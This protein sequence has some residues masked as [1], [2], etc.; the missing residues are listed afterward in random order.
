VLSTYSRQ[1][2]ILIGTPVANRVRPELEGLVGLFANTLVLRTDTSGD[3]SFRELVRRVRDLT[4]QA[5]AHQDLPFERLVDEL[6]VER[7]LSHNPLFQ[8]MLA[9]QHGAFGQHELPGLTLAGLN[10]RTRTSKFDLTLEVE[11][12]SD[13]LAGQL[14]Y[15][16]DLFDRDTVERL[17]DQLATL[18]GGVAA[19]ADRRLSQ[20]PLLSPDERQ[21]LLVDFNATAQPLPALQTL[22]ALLEA[23]AK[24]SPEAVAVVSES[25]R[26]TY[27]ALH[28]RAN[29]LAHHLRTLG[30]G[31]DVRVGLCVDRSAGGCPGHSQ[32][33]RRLRP[34][35]PDLSA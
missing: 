15:S 28:S 3:P 32:G 11:E 9:V 26:L 4:L 31:P 7:R 13:A 1:H 19:D 16:T 6:Q 10:S 12:T 22:P 5:Y 17:L 33:R 30:V 27:T 21:R 23:Q 25:G 35:G 18:L 34:A 14:E 20:L 2:D 29:Q 8:V 24:R